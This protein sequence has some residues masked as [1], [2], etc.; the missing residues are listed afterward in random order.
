MKI[1][2]EG[3]YD[4][5]TIEFSYTDV[6]L[7]DMFRA[8]ITGMIFL[9]YDYETIINFIKSYVKELEELEELDEVSETEGEVND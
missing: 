6:D 3:D 9:T 2:F 7:N 5:L 1:I 8:F 4:K